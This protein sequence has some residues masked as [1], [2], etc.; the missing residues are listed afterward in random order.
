MEI[1]QSKKWKLSGRRSA[2]FKLLYPVLEYSTCAFSHKNVT[3]TIGENAYTNVCATT[4]VWL[5]GDFISAFASLE[6]HKNH[7]LVKIALM[8]SGQDVPQLAHVPYPKTHITVNDYK[9]HP[10]SIKRV[11]AVMHANQHYAVIEITID[12]KPSRSLMDYI[13]LLS[14]IGKTM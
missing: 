7:S 8:K 5:D 11:V 10:S 14:L 4:D 3:I 2:N 13:D 9:T 1:L 12:T 6:C